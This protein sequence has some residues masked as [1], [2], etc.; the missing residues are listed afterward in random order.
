MLKLEG[1]GSPSVPYTTCKVSP[2]NQ[3]NVVDIQTQVCAVKVCLF[4]TS[5]WSTVSYHSI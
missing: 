4:S 5:A 2:T 3:V 1:W